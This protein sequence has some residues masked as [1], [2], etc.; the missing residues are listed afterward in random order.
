MFSTERL[1]GVSDFAFT[2]E[3]DEYV[4]RSL[5]LQFCDCF[6]DHLDLI[7]ILVRPI[8]VDYWAIPS[9]DGIHTP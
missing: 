7:A 3:E 6:A 4:T 2:A 5:S 1:G 8:G 9:L